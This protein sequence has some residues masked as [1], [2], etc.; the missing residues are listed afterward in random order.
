MENPYHKLFIFEFMVNSITVCVEN[1][2]CASYIQFISRNTLKDWIAFWINNLCLYFDLAV[3]CLF[4]IVT[5]KFIFFI[6]LRSI[7]LILIWL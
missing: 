6:W 1:L 3:S 7:N 2:D 4:Y 5:A